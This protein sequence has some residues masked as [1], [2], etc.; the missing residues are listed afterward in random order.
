MIIAHVGLD[1][2]AKSYGMTMDALEAMRRGKEVWSL[3]TIAGAGKLKNPH[4]L[5]FLYDAVVFLDELQR[6]YPTSSQPPDEIIQHIISTHRHQKLV[7]HWAS[8]DFSFVNAWIR[9]ETTYAWKYEALHRDHLTGESRWFGTRL[10]RHERILVSGVAAEREWR[11]PHVYKKQTFF[12]KKSIAE[13]FNTHENMEVVLG[14]PTKQEY[15]ATLTDPH[16]EQSALKTFPNEDPQ[17][18]GDHKRFERN[19]EGGEGGKNI[20]RKDQADE[21]NSRSYI[22]KPGKGKTG[23]RKRGRGRKNGDQRHQ[24][25]TNEIE[26]QG[27]DH[28]LSEVVATGDFMPNPP[29]DGGS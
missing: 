2:S 18:P 12:I 20:E 26:K 13:K 4:Q 17:S 5:L 15:I 27:N 28:T 1:G 19:D 16:N 23:K 9:R 3:T 21:R 29:A 24:Q 14:D 7:I 22:V 10:K 8:Q 25:Q 11:Q 6:W